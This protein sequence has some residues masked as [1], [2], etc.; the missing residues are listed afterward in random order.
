MISRPVQTRRLRK[1]SRQNQ[2]TAPDAWLLPRLHLVPW[3]CLPVSLWSMAATSTTVCLSPHMCL[4]KYGPFLHSLPVLSIV[5]TSLVDPNMGKTLIYVA[6]YFSLGRSKYLLSDLDVIAPLSPL[7]WIGASLFW[8]HPCHPQHSHKLH[9]S[10]YMDDLMLSCEFQLHHSPWI[11]PLV[12]SISN[13]A[14]H[15]GLVPAMPSTAHFS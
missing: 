1:P 15:F 7:S 14:G 4:Q 10:S 8:L 9:R 11:L 3:L 13:L 12:H 2:S 5:L 6:F